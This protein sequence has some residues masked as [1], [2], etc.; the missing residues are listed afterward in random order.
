MIDWYSDNFNGFLFFVTVMCSEFL[1]MK[2]DLNVNKLD[3]K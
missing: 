3:V 2:C 1:C